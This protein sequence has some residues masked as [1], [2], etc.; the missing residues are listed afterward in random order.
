[1]PISG[2]VKRQRAVVT[3]AGLLLVHNI[4][5]LHFTSAQKIL[6]SI[7]SMLLCEWKLYWSETNEKVEE[8]QLHTREELTGEGF[9]YLYYVL[10]EL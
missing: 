9:V 7:V 8:V 6:S 5:D 2:P 3:Q 1:M 10:N 4:I